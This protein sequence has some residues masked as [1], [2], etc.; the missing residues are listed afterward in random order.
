MDDALAGQFLEAANRGVDVA[1]IE[2][3][4]K[5]RP[6]DALGRNDRRATAHE[7]IDDEITALANVENVAFEVECFR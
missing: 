1:G 5:S 6:T 3:H 2:I 4:S 7:R